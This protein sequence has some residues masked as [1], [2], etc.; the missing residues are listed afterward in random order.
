MTFREQLIQ[1]EA[2]PE[3]VEWVGNKTLEEAWAECGRFDWMW[4]VAWELA[5]KYF[6]ED[7]MSVTESELDEALAGVWEGDFVEE[8]A[9][10][11]RRLVQHEMIAAALKEK[12]L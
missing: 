3:A 6:R 8:T 9:S 2:C 11:M 4:W 1:M 5:T 12:Q 10:V 7:D